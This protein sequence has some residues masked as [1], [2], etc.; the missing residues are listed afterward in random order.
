MKNTGKRR[1]GIQGRG[2]KDK[3]DEKKKKTRR[4]FE[5]EKKD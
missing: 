5:D 3:E 4:P 1:R 2:E